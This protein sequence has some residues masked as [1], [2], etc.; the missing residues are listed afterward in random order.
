MPPDVRKASGFPLPLYQTFQQ[1]QGLA[2][3]LKGK[4]TVVGKAEP[5]RTSG[6]EAAF[7]TNYIPARA[8]RALPMPACVDHYLLR[9]DR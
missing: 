5:Y 6:G 2:L 3:P 7:T 1:R 9:S 4:R 8:A